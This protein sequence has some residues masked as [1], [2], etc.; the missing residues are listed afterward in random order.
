MVLLTHLAD[1]QAHV[2][3]GEVADIE[4]QA[5]DSTCSPQELA[6]LL[7]YGTVHGEWSTEV[8]AEGN[9]LVA[10]GRRVTVISE[11]NPELL[12]WREYGIELAVDATGK[13]KERSGMEKHRLAGEGKVLITAPGHRVG[14]DYVSC[15]PYRIP[16]ARIAAAQAAI[17]HKRSTAKIKAV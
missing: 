6:H 7:Q 17:E 14:L 1:W 10:N 3:V 2:L 4:L 9:E 5:I 11:R 15:S 8:H 13:F 16:M 12:P